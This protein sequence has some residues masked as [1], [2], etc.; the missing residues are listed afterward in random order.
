MTSQIL[1]NF[2]HLLFLPFKLLSILLFVVVVVVFSPFFLPLFSQADDAHKFGDQH[3]QGHTVEAR[4]RVASNQGPTDF[5]FL[6][7]FQMK[8]AEHFCRWVLNASASNNSTMSFR[9]QI[10][11]RCFSLLISLCVSC[12]HNECSISISFHCKYSPQK[13][14]SLWT[15][16]WSWNCEIENAW[17]CMDLKLSNNLHRSE[18]ILQ[19]T[20]KPQGFL[21]TIC[22]NFRITLWY[23]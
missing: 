1:Q 4:S 15:E 3:A 11:L 10:D 23:T 14:N 6:A 19:F 5:K 9:I 17:I 12:V 7:N 20:E 2:H 16:L 13:W 18:W 21:P 8:L 22:L